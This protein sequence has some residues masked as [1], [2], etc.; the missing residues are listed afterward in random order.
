MISGAISRGRETCARLCRVHERL[1]HDPRARVGVLG[2]APE[3]GGVRAGRQIRRRLA[4]E[5][6]DRGTA[7]D[8][9]AIPRRLAGLGV[10]GRTL[11]ARVCH[12]PAPCS[13]EAFCCLRRRAHHCPSVFGNAI[14]PLP[15]VVRLEAVGLVGRNPIPFEGDCRCCGHL[16]S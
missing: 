7:D 4:G 2:H 9:Q 15:Y 1:R 16:P 14:V 5:V 13:W 12:C 3:D 6:V 10:P 8:R 11:R